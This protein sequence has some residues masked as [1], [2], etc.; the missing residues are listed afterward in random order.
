MALC[1][2]SK[3]KG[4]SFKFQQ[5]TLKV[6]LI[7]STFVIGNFEVEFPSASWTKTRISIKKL[8]MDC[9]CRIVRFF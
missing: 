9:D 4:G 7:P 8:E 5:A 2:G 3:T 6:R 1:S